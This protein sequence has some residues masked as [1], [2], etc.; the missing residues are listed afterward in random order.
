MVAGPRRAALP[1]GELRPL[2]SRA[3]GRSDASGRRARRSSPGG[4]ARFVRGR[5]H[6]ALLRRRRT[7]ARSRPRPS[8]GAPSSID[9]SSRGGWTRASRSSSP[10]QPRRCRRARGHHRQPELLDDA[11]RAPAHG[12]PRRGRHGARHRRYLPV[13]VRHRRQGRRR[14]RGPGPRPR[15][16]ASRRGERLSAPDRVQ[17]PPEIDVFLDNGYTKEEW[18]VVTETRK[19]LHLPDLRISCTAVRIPVFGAT[20]RPSTSR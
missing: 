15:R 8:R 10:G 19:I 2:A 4:D 11:A 18:K 12:A 6:R 5:R 14:A 13:G 20:R 3:D 17:R 9:N 7:S 1:V 16:R